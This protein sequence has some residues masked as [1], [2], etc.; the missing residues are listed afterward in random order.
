M[1]YLIITEFMDIFKTDE[2]TEETLEAHD[3]G[4][5][6]VIDIENERVLDDAQDEK[7]SD[8]PTEVE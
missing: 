4:V 7:W 2:L 1:K 8:I 5:L 6:I 3:D